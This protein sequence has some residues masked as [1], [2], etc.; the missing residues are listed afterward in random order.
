[1]EI[2]VE[3]NLI[4]KTLVLKQF[5]L[6]KYLVGYDWENPRSR[7]P[8]IQFQ[9]IKLNTN[10]TNIYLWIGNLKLLALNKYLLFF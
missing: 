6:F 1:M 3:P 2:N 10:E 8:Q 5:S 7:E 9:E 4:N